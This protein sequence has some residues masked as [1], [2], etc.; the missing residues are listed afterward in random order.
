[1]FSRLQFPFSNYRMSRNL[2][3]RWYPLIEF[4]CNS[5]SYMLQSYETENCMF[6]VDCLR[7]SK[8]IILYLKVNSN[9]GTNPLLDL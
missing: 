8:A 7:A 3:E 6:T 1:M 5:A 9:R 2:F 4:F